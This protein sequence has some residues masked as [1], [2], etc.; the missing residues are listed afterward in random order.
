MNQTICFFKA[1]SE[2]ITHG[3]SI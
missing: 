2:T 3:I 1:L